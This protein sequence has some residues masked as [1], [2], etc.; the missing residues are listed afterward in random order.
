MPRER[1]TTGVEIHDDEIRVV[2]VKQKGGHQVPTAVFFEALPHGAVMNGVVQQPGV[3]AVALQKAIDQCPYSNVTQVVVGVSASGTTARSLSLP[4]CSD[5]EFRSLLR[6][7]VQFQRV[8]QT[9]GGG[10][11]CVEL[12]GTKED[13]RQAAVI[14]V[15]QGILSTYDEVIDR[16]MV[17]VMAVEPVQFAILRSF[18]ERVD[19]KKPTLL[20]MVSPVATDLVFFIEGKPAFFRRIDVG[21][22][23]L[24]QDAEQLGTGLYPKLHA[25]DHLCTEVRRSLDFLGRETEQVALLE[26][27]ILSI[28]HVGLVPLH[29]FF[30]ERLGLPVELLRPQAEHFQK[31]ELRYE[32]CDSPESMR[33]MAAFGLALFQSDA[34]ASVTPR[35]DLSGKF[36]AP[37][38]LKEHVQ[39]LSIPIA[40]TAAV[41]L[42]GTFLGIQFVTR[43]SLLEAQAADITQQA[44]D[45]RKEADLAMGEQ[46]RRL[47]QFDLLKREGVPLPTIIDGITRSLSNGVGLVSVSVSQQQVIIEGEAT[48]E[49]AMLQTLDNL[50]SSPV[51]RDLAVSS[52]GRDQANDKGIRFQLSGSTVTMG[53]IR[54]ASMENNL[55]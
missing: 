33:Y 9:P 46:A 19:K 4:P 39:A 45:V 40:I 12:A 29:N 43:T 30:E 17:D 36:G 26:R 42:V 8:L 5:E 25:L 6:A 2:Q 51:L 27:L 35:V 13:F 53:D 11:G 54:V 18:A 47:K 23:S 24:A 21:S 38:T 1:V 49:A 52:F 55:R 28:D 3:V 41:I 48:N 34:L 44:T 31:K 14:A 20:L 22:K 15:E 32:L 10:F 37:P 7:E 50:R 16:S